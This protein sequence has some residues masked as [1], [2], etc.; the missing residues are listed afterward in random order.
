MCLCRLD[1]LIS[2]H[3]VDE[4]PEEDRKWTFDLMKTCVR[5]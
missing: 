5:E 1:V 4:V 2:F 3:P